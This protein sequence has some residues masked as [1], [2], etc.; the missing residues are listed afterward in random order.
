MTTQLQERNI[1]LQ[2]AIEEDRQETNEDLTT[3]IAKVWQ[4]LTWILEQYPQY[5]FGNP[6]SYTAS[7]LEVV[8]GRGS[9]SKL[10]VSNLRT[11]E[12][13]VHIVDRVLLPAF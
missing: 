8:D 12:A 11:C 13:I 2:I 1:T 3:A 6:K 10:L 5:D 4:D 9:Q 7:G